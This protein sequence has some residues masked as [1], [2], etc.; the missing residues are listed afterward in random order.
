M[1]AAGAVGCN[2]EDTDHAAGGH[3]LRDADHQAERL[4]AFKRAG[5]DAGVDLVLNARVDVFLRQ[6]DRRRRP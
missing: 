1:L 3:T 2:L 4:S 5:R 6:A